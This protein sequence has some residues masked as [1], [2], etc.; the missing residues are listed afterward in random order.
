MEK[1]DMKEIT[2]LE[3]MQNGF[4]QP[5][6]K[7]IG[8]KDIDP[9][10][11]ETL[12]QCD[13][14]TL[15]TS[16]WFNKKVSR[17]DLNKGNIEITGA[18]NWWWLSFSLTET[19][20]SFLNDHGR[21]IF[22]PGEN[23]NM[24]TAD[25]PMLMQEERGLYY[26]KIGGLPQDYQ[27]FSY[28]TIF[29]TTDMLLHFYHKIFS[30]ALRFYEESTARTIMVDL[31]ESMFSKFSNLYQQNK[32]TALAPY[33]AYATAY[34]AI[35][36]TLLVPQDEVMVA[37]DQKMQNS[38]SDETDLTNEEIKALSLQKLA[39]IES[40][41]PTFYQ[42]AVKTTLQNIFA[43]DQ[44]REKDPLLITLAGTN[45]EAIDIQQDYTQFT[46]RS[47]YTKSSLLKTYFMGMKWFMREKLYFRDSEQTKASLV[48][49]NNIQNEELTSFSQLYDAIQKLIGEDDD[50]NIKDI[51]DFIQT[52]WW[53]SDM[54][55]ID[56]VSENT[57]SELKKLRPQRIVSTHYQT[58]EIL[59]VTE[60]EA[61]D[62]TAGFVFFGE[63]FTIDSW[64]F[65]RMTA[66][67]AEKEFT[68][69]PNVQTSLIVPDGLVNS[70]FIQDLV[71][72]W[73]QKAQNKYKVTSTQIDWYSKAKQEA[74]SGIFNHDFSRSTYHQWLNDLWWL[75]ALSGNNLPYFMQDPLW[76]YK[77]LNTFQWN[78]TELKHDT[79]LYVKQAYAEWGMWW[80]DECSVIINPPA[81]P[82]PKG[83]VE[84]NIDLVD[85]LLT[86][87]EQTKQFFGDNASFE[88]FNDFLLFVKN[89]A[90]KESSNQIISD[91]DY[92][93]LRLYYDEL[94]SILYPQKVIDG[95]DNDFISALI[96]DI[97]TSEKNGPLYI[98]NGRPY[99][100]IANIK[101]ANGARAVIWPVYSTFE[102]YGSDDAITGE[103][104]RYT[105]EERRA[106]LDAAKQ[107]EIITLP[108]QKILQK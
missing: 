61:K 37:L 1:P 38:T 93:T 34:R 10:R 47:H 95:G 9:S 98:A 43:A 52:A 108:L 103:K 24:R 76:K 44:S 56:S 51:Q 58:P 59:S 77:E 3:S 19:Q 39:N 17:N 31:S 21:L 107:D 104:W 60:Q 23:R 6:K 12:K 90:I 11:V 87:T 13:T 20:K 41:I 63:K 83:Y 62:E 15:T 70:G 36:Y 2:N 101:D 102:F 54:N 45:S 94:M 64:I 99:L 75:F 53:K 69:K 7:I 84:P 8:E 57:Q 28:N 92:E 27:R 74:Q 68:Y 86:L 55:I 5:R 82:V 65:D 18:Y 81:L 26:Q 97:F 66:G 48:M 88:P 85:E 16:Q 40:K 73:M 106:W 72:I 89:M 22:N 100:L 49:I 67:T 30:N 50:V 42:E 78:Y 96:A 35:P 32:D 79:L 46:P 91:D 105:D 14:I 4:Q 33:Y 71:D 29:V 25:N 80:E